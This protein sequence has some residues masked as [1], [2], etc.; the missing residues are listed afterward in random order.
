MIMK[1][2]ILLTMALCIYVVSDAQVLS[3]LPVQPMMTEIPNA[4]ASNVQAPLHPYE[5][6]IAPKKAAHK[7]TA[8]KSRLKTTSYFEPDGQT[9]I[10]TDS[11][12]YEYSGE[13]GGDLESDNI[14]CDRYYYVGYDKVSNSFINKYRGNYTY[15]TNNKVAVDLL[16]IWA[17][18]TWRNHTKETNT[19][20]GSGYLTEELNQNWDTVN[21]VW[22]NSWL[23]NFTYDGQNN[24][25][26]RATKKWNANNN[27]WVNHGE[28][29]YAFNGALMSERSNRTW[30]AQNNVWKN[31]YRYIYSYNNDNLLTTETYYLWD[32][33]I[34]SWKE[35]I[36]YHRTY[37]AAK[38]LDTYIGEQENGGVWKNYQ[39]IT[40]TYNGLNQELTNI[41]QDWKN[42]AWEN[43]TRTINAYNTSDDLITY[44]FEVWQPNTN[45]WKNQTKNLYEYDANKNITKKTDQEPDKNNNAVW[46]NYKREI[47]TYNAYNQLLLQYDQ[48][49][50]ANNWT[51]T[52]FNS[53][54][55]HTYE[56]YTVTVSVSKYN[57]LNAD[58]KMYPNPA[59]QFLNVDVVL[60]QAENINITLVDMAGRTVMT[61]AYNATTNIHE[62]ISISHLSAGIYNCIINTGKEQH[63]QQI[64]V[65]K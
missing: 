20:N 1:K 55:S 59:A 12:T 4:P 17:V 51:L 19:Y 26:L 47:S 21:N 23:Y 57:N 29:I 50:L 22:V 30:D 63:T 58:V 27:A 45:S 16:E 32:K 34:N 43:S 5:A 40:I 10:Y 6:Q 38:L 14:D 41:S 28:D 31:N 3:K 13:R 64:S 61:K 53:Q 33:N 62:Q 2:Y 56:D 15:N 60:P 52:Q 44:T 36:R 37:N 49:Y 65:V 54:R 39:K 11:V 42:N 7:T 35:A 25:T 48:N 18:G 24:L 9:F 46:V 8:I